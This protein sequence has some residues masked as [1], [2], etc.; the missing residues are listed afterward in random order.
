MRRATWPQSLRCGPKPTIR[1]CTYLYLLLVAV[2]TGSTNLC[3]AQQVGVSYYAI[4]SFSSRECS[5]ALRVFDNIET[6]AL[7]MLWSTFGS[8]KRCLVKYLDRFTSRPHTLE[9]HITNN[10]CLRTR[11]CRRG[12]I[13]RDMSSRQYN[14][15]LVTRD[16]DLMR[17]LRHRVREIVS[18]LKRY[19]SPHTTIILTT[20]LEDDY[21]L[22]AYKVVFDIL[23]KER[24]RLSFLIA[25]NPNRRNPSIGI[26]PGADLLELHGLSPR[27][28]EDFA[29]RCIA[30]NDGTDIAFPLSPNRTGIS[31]PT[32][33]IPRSVY[34]P[35]LPHLRVVVRPSGT[36]LQGPGGTKS[37]PPTLRD[38]KR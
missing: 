27:F 31:L 4:Q 25:R 16:K 26:A 28:P 17:S 13:V 20:G 7:S 22:K 15:L 24:R 6:P 21:S 37:I 11:K 8:D 14:R 30:N 38:P 1:G 9:I 2:I 5:T 34:S 10:T 32:D 3:E 18:F 36:P 19:A 23:L 33:Q 29:G 35:G 12:E